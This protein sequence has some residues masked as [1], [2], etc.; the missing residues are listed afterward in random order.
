M[1]FT[2]KHPW[3]SC[4]MCCITVFLFAC[5]SLTLYKS[6]DDKLRNVHLHPLRADDITQMVGTPPQDCDDFETMFIGVDLKLK[7]PVI[8]N[9][10]IGSPAEKAGMKVGDKI[11]QVGDKK[12]KT[13]KAFAELIRRDSNP[14]IPLS[15]LTQRGEFKVTPELTR[16]KQCEWET[17]ADKAGQPPK[18]V[19]AEKKKG[20]K[21][22]RFFRTTCRIKDGYAIRC[23]TQW[24]D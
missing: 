6:W 24:R 16:F 19:P 3:V 12:I 18:A 14:V 21:K 10:A 7:K 5:S 15:I 1:V 8:W 22:G 20:K 4:L 11:K 23:L 2:R 13:S 9:I 17:N